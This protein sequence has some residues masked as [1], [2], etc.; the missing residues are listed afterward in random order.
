MKTLKAFLLILISISGMQSFADP[1]RTQFSSE[2]KHAI[3]LIIDGLSYKAWDK[4]NL[5]VLEKMADTG[6]RVDQVFLPP[7]AHPKAGEYAELHSGSIPNPIM[8]SGTVFITR[9][10]EY[11]QDKF[12]PS[13]TAAFVANSL[14]YNT[15]TDNYHYV[16]QMGGSDASSIDMALQFMD[17]GTP[18]F[19]RIH[20]QEPGGAGSRSMRVEEDVPWRRNIWGNGSPYREYIARADSLVG[21]LID[22]LDERNILKD[23][24]II[25][26]G[27]HG[28]ND[29]GWHPPE[30]WD[31]AITTAVLWGSRIKVNARIPYAELIDIAPTVCTI[32][33]VDP[34]SS[35]IGRVMAEALNKYDG[36]PGPRTEYIKELNRMFI[37]YREKMSEAQWLVE[38]APVE[39]QGVMFTSLDREIRENF[40]HIR[41]F[42][43]W[44]R[45]STMEELVI[46]NRSVL[47]RL[48]SLLSEIRAVSGKEG[49]IAK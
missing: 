43:E 22:G 46:H 19:M 44:P 49:S 16:Y 36:D 13:K 39:E 17:T 37:E 4:M 14:A 27:D 26:L 11:I 29:T 8:M 20:L 25:V 30:M 35:S 23:T 10:T 18:A 48:D 38:R 34:P 12:F 41:R 45:F 9:N 42:S 28:Q 6:A 47:S 1:F 21:V 40:F 2:P 7:A 24:A 3:L 32:M 31:S 15:L 33:N 5:P